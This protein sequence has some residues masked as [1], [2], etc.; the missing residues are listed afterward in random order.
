M[1]IGTWEDDI[2][3]LM[4]LKRN[5]ELNETDYEDVAEKHNTTVDEVIACLGVMEIDSSIYEDQLCDVCFNPISGE[6]ADTYCGLCKNCYDNHG[7]E[8]FSEE[9]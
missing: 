4:E 9:D 3:R 8:Y 6:E 2:K 5:G 1:V 7:E